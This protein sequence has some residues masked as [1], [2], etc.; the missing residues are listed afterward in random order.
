M[1][2]RRYTE[3]MHA[4]IDG[5]N[6]P[7]ESRELREY[8][9][10]DPDALCRFR[11]LK[12]VARVLSE[13]GQV[14]PPATLR[15]SIM[16]AVADRGRSSS[17]DG[18]LARLREVLSPAPRTRL[19][20]AF[21]GGVA[22]GL[23]LFAALSVALPRMGTV[24]GGGSDLFGTMG[25]RCFVATDPVSF[26]VPG[27]AG[28]ASVRYCAE[29]VTLE[30]S[31]SSDSEVVVVLSY[32]DEVD[33]DGVRAL[34]PGDHAIRVTGHSAELTHAGTRDYDLYFTDYT[35]SHLPMRM[36][37]MAAGM[38]VFESSVPPGRE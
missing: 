27:A 34:Q 12:E 18:Y 13:A 36:S 23:V 30:L 28:R 3:L 8:L 14:S 19:A 22:V 1:S 24:P 15:R 33:F 7:D 6:S 10:G 2:D 9:E 32:D 20:Y 31:L 38:P 29:T 17:A 26:D 37:V 11:E 16:S 21:A 25:G 4:E 5:T 35:E